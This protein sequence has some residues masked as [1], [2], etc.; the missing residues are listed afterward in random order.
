MLNSFMSNIFRFAQFHNLI[1]ACD[2][3]EGTNGADLLRMCCDVPTE[4]T[5]TL[6]V[7]SFHFVQQF[8]SVC[9]LTSKLPRGLHVP[10]SVRQ[11]RSHD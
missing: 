1:K 8:V 3:D 5:V 7:C 9:Y 6:P 4:N 2:E 10:A 11:P